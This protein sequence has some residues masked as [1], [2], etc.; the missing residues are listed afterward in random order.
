MDPQYPSKIVKYKNL[1]PGD[2]VIYPHPGMIV[3]VDVKGKD[4]SWGNVPN[5]THYDIYDCAYGSLTGP[6][7]PESR[8]LVL[9]ERKDILDMYKKIDYQLLEQI[10]D[11]IDR[12]KEFKNVFDKAINSRNLKKWANRKKKSKGD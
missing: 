2:A 9:T 4:P 8:C 10:A 11:G 7:H 3:H 1:K 6:M 5:I 12:R